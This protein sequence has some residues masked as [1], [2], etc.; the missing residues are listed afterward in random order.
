MD[1]VDALRIEKSKEQKELDLPILVKKKKA[2]LS[3]ILHDALVSSDWV[4]T[5]KFLKKSSEDKH[6]VIRKNRKAQYDIIRN[7]KDELCKC[8]YDSALDFYIEQKLIST[9]FYELTYDFS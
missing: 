9:G 6:K 7:L 8:D 2:Q 5:S 1:P 4:D 3:K